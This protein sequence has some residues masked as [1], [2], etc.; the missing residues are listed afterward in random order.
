[1]KK[2]MTEIKENDNM[3][4]AYLFNFIKQMLNCSFL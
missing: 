2:L 3:I 1:V 4:S